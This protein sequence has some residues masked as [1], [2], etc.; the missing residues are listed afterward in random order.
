VRI[1]EAHEAI[2]ERVCARDPVGAAA[3]MAVHF[4]LSVNSLAR[5]QHRGN[6]T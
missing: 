2:I 4:D 1:I 5:A 3:A 6:L